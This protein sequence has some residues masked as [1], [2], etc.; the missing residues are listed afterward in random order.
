MEFTEML[1]Q[2][3]IEGAGQGDVVFIVTPPDMQSDAFLKFANALRSHVD[4]ERADGKYLPRCIVMPPGVTVEV[5]R[6]QS[7]DRIE[8]VTDVTATGQMDAS[9]AA[10]LP[11]S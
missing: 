5:A 8:I 2:I 6:A 4:R 7:Q 1:E 3:Q 9:P 11:H 10:G